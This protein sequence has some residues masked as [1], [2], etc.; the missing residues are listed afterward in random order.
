MRCLRLAIALLMLLANVESKQINDASST[1]DTV[2]V[3][4]RGIG[5]EDGER[6]FLLGPG[7]A[8]RVFRMVGPSVVGV[9]TPGHGG[10][11]VIISEDGL[12]LT[13]DHVIR[14][15]RTHGGTILVFL[16]DKRIYRAIVKGSDPIIDVVVLQLLRDDHDGISGRSSLPNHFTE[17]DVY[18]LRQFATAA[19]WFGNSMPSS[20]AWD[21]P[22]PVARFGNSSSLEVGTQVLR[23]GHGLDYGLE[24]TSGVVSGFYWNE[25]N[26]VV[27]S[28]MTDAASFR[29]FSGGPLIDME[30]GVV[31]GINRLRV[32]SVDTI[33]SSSDVMSIGERNVAVPIDEIKDVLP[34]MMEG[35]HVTHGTIGVHLLG[36]SR[37]IPRGSLTSGAEII[38]IDAWS[39]AWRRK[40]LRRGDV[41]VEIGG[42]RVDTAV[43]AR[44]L[45]DRATVGEVSC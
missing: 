18:L 29:G 35:K 10:T 41:I 33:R 25:E 36:L 13:C 5:N 32:V 7:D 39:P 21:D 42:E 19:T 31:V 4:E 38:K 8:A 44:R 11:G 16:P 20:I 6:P 17:D 28:I 37:D 12:V 30:N 40:R 15:A 3:D 2:I 26:I 23:L 14:D 24:A 27:R 43:D 9:Y 34:S 22:F 1:S 45:I